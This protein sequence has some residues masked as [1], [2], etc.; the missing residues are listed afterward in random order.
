MNKK[1]YVEY[2]VCGHCG[3]QIYINKEIG[4]NQTIPIYCPN[5]CHYRDEQLKNLKKRKRGNK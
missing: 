2:I 4:Y 5:C 1:E 3:E